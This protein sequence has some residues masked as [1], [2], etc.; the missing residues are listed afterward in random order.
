MLPVDNKSPVL[1]AIDSNLILDEGKCVA[2]NV[3]RLLKV[4]DEDTE[5]EN[6]FFRFKKSPENGH[7]GL[8]L[9]TPADMTRPYSNTELN[10]L[11]YCHD[12]SETT[13]DRI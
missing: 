9:G 11:K 2:L 3:N 12:D 5:K 4:K 7:I 10:Q 6:F 8:P 13:S 1:T